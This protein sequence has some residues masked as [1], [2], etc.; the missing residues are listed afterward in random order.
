[1]E[2]RN[3]LI[4]IIVIGI[5]FIELNFK[6]SNSVCIKQISYDHQVRNV[7][8]NFREKLAKSMNKEFITDAEDAITL[9]S[10]K[11]IYVITPTYERLSR[12]MEL[13]RMVQA[14]ML[15]GGIYWILV[16]DAKNYSMGVRKVAYDSGL[17]FAHVLRKQ[18]KLRAGHRGIDQRN[19]GLDIVRKVGLPGIIYFADDDNVYD[20]RLFEELRTIKTVGLFATGFAGGANFEKCVVNESG[21]ITGFLS[22]WPGGRKFQV[23]M[24]G[25]AINSEILGDF[26]I[27][28]TMEPG[29]IED[30][31]VRS[32]INSPSEAQPIGNCNTVYFWHIAKPSS[33]A[34]SQ[35]KRMLGKNEKYWASYLPP[36]RIYNH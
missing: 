10:K 31:I 7:S 6:I 24:G 28:Y 29:Y 32:F 13:T 2:K 34:M 8:L 18:K 17:P 23:D 3:H 5:F 33:R 9:T 30:Y 36:L 27:P 21:I 14:L 1:M 35:M 19:A 4:L 12:K 26:T 22:G 15:D 11:L 25:F 20:Y 16:E